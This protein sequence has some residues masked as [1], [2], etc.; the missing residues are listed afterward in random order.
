MRAIEATQTVQASEMA[1]L[2]TRSEAVIRLWYEGSVM[3]KSQFMADVEG[4]V[5]KVERLVRRVEHERDAAKE[6]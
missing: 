4:R 6:I 2:R 5:E 1:E 3:E